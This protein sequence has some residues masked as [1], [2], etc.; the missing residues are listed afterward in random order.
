[1]FI[2]EVG[3]PV[4]KC[5]PFIRASL[6]VFGKRFTLVNENSRFIGR[7]KVIDRKMNEP[8]NY[9]FKFNN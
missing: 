2:N 3:P 6:N 9:P 8:Y 4:G 1:M 5:L 7:G